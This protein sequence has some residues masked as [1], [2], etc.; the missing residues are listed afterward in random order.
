ML[1]EINSDHL[2]SNKYLKPLEQLMLE[3]DII[4]GADS[5]SIHYCVS[6]A[7]QLFQRTYL[8]FSTIPIKD[9]QGLLYLDSRPFVFAMFE[10]MV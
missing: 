8:R 6:S 4:F 3:H 10:S 1:L 5:S 9:I 7:A 2:Y